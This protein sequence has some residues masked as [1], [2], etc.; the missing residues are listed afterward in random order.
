MFFVTIIFSRINVYWITY[1]Y[2]I[3]N[4]FYYNIVMF[5][6][7]SKMFK[8]KIT[9]SKTKEN[10]WSQISEVCSILRLSNLDSY[11]FLCLYNAFCCCDEY[12]L[13]DPNILL[14]CGFGCFSSLLIVEL[15][16]SLFLFFVVRVWVISK[17]SF[18]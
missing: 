1:F 5:K 3:L 12:V 10:W 15:L 9:Y 18:S 14:V 16:I 13:W 6:D 17:M 7:K 4:N 11:C 8:K 2:F